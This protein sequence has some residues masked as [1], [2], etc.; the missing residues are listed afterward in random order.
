MRRAAEMIPAPYMHTR[1]R[2][3]E[4]EGGF[5]AATIAAAAALL[6]R[7]LSRPIVT[8]AAA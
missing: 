2:E 7:S 6:S 3:L 8:D 1:K 5:V 4:E